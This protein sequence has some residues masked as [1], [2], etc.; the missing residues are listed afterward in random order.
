MGTSS[1]ANG[2]DGGIAILTSDTPRFIVNAQGNVGIGTQNPSDLLEVAHPSSWAA[3][4]VSGG[5]GGG[6]LK[7]KNYGNTTSG[8]IIEDTGSGPMRFYTGGAEKVRLDSTGRLGIG[9]TSP[10]TTIDINGAKLMRANPG[11]IGLNTFT[12]G[13]G[14]SAANGGEIEFMHQWTG[15]MH[16]GD[17]IVFTYNATSWKS[18]WFEITAAST[19]GYGHSHIGGYWNNS[20]GVDS[21]E[22]I[23]A[24]MWSISRSTSGQAIIVTVT[25]NVTWIHPLIKIKF[26]CGG[27][28]GIPKI[29]RCSLVITS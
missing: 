5:G 15:T 8:S 2:G 13:N 26:G 3:I 11:G 12:V 20:G 23:A 17:T 1:G 6:T 4:R 27:G 24:S 29:D 28:E 25:L 14:M 9:T 10:T 21:L 16:S 22:T 7:F 18:W 19:G